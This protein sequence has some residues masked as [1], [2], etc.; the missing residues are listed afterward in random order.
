MSFFVD[1]NAK[2]QRRTVRRLLR[3][4]WRCGGV[5]GRY[6][7]FW[8]GVVGDLETIKIRVR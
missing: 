6:R 2:P 5:S 7:H 3:E 1:M 8:R 4:G